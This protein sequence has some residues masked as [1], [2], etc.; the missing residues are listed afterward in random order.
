[1][2]FLLIV[3][4]YPIDE[5]PA[6]S[7]GTL[8]IA[9]SLIRQGHR[10][11]VVDLLL[12]EA[13]REK[14]VAAMERLE[15]H[16]VGVTSVTMTFPM[17]GEILRWAK[18]A[19][20][21]VI[22]IMGG[23]HVSFA[24]RRSLRECPWADVILRGEAEVTVVELARALDAKVDLGC[25][26]GLTYRTED[27][28][29]STPD[30]PSVMDLQG[31]PSPC[32]DL[33]PLARYRA[34]NAK[35]GVLSSR[36]CPYGCIF[37]VGHKMVGRRGR[38]RDPASVV[39]EMEEL[40][41]WGFRSI[42]I[43]DDLFTLHEA[44]AEAVCMEISSRGLPVSWHAFARVDRVS[45]RLLEMMAQCGCTDIC[46]GVESG[47][48][49]ILDRIKKGFDLQQVRKAV[50]WALDAGINVL[51]SFI[52]GLPGETPE[53]LRKTESFAGSL[54]CRYGFHVL[55]PFPGTKVRQ[56][57]ANYGI[58]ILTDEWSLYDANRPVCLP[59]SLTEE[60]IWG[61]LNRYF[62]DLSSYCMSQE[63]RVQNSTASERDRAEVWQ[64]KTRTV[65]WD[66]LRMDLIEKL[67]VIPCD[68]A[69]EESADTLAERI[70][71]AAPELELPWIRTTLEHW[72]HEGI[73][74]AQRSSEGWE[75]RWASNQE[76][77]STG[78]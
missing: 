5:F 8:Y 71:M 26:A 35:V 66:V 41:S 39:D 15:P 24:P 45:P 58:R 30:R 12:S 20:P 75:F 78:G 63:E 13:T 38:F 31:I 64:R 27:G 50:D 74:K 1:M 43:D 68:G 17:A 36:G 48:Q 61:V 4:P 60:D 10:V 51:A 16:V 67:G 33:L 44:H 76:L 2:K 54:G 53:T 28:I 40:A 9:S 32:W 18:E 7:T 59:S 56:R 34:L 21:A 49:E 6:I 25:V 37:C 42:G 70:N 72:L 29:R 19:N 62:R 65:A 69:L 52:L 55:A 57:A 3:P 23:P 11:E 46:Y 73:L 77:K 47:C 14:V 22:T